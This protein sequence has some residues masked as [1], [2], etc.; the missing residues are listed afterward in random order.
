[1]KTLQ[2]VLDEHP[3]IEVAKKLGLQEPV[4][5][6][7]NW[8]CPI[9]DDQNP[10]LSISSEKNLWYCHTC[11]IGGNIY[12]LIMKVSDC[13]FSNALKFLGEEPLY[14]Q[15]K[16]KYTRDNY[17]ESHGLSEE[18]CKKFGFQKSF[19]QSK[20]GK[21]ESIVFPNLKGEHHRVFKGKNKFLTVGE[22]TLWKSDEATKQII[23]AEGESKA[24]LISQETGLVAWASTGGKGTFKKAWISEFDDVEEI[25]VV[26]DNDYPKDA[27]D[28]RLQDKVLRFLPSEKV[29][30][31]NFSYDYKDITDWFVEGKHTG[32]EFKELLKDAQNLASNYSEGDMYAPRNNWEEMTLEELTPLLDKTIKKDHAAKTITFLAMLL[33]YTEDSQLNVIFS[34]DSSSGKSYVSLELGK[35]FPKEDIISLGGASPTS[36]IHGNGNYDKEKKATIVDLERKI[37]IFK[38]MQI[39]ALLEKLRS[40]LSHDEKET[41]Y[42]VTDRNKRGQNRAKKI[43]IKGFPSV[44]F[45]SAKYKIDEQELTRSIVLSPEYS[46]EKIE[47]SIT[48]LSQKLRDPAA[49]SDNL[50]HDPKRNDLMKR[51]QDIRHAHINNVKI[52]NIE[53]LEQEFMQ[54]TKYLPPRAM[55]DYMKVASLVKALALLNLWNRKRDGK[56]ILASDSDID[57]A[58]V[59]WDKI[60]ISQELG[61]SPAL[62]DF[63]T[64]I[65]WEA[66]EQ[67]TI[68]LSKKD[69]QAK[70]VQLRKKQIPD[71]KLRQEILEMLLN[72]G[73]ISEERDESDKRNILYSAVFKPSPETVHTP[74]SQHNLGSE[75]KIAEEKNGRI[76]SEGVVYTRDQNS[77][78][79][80]TREPL[81]SELNASKMPESF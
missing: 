78:E 41:I 25:V 71:W 13:N 75:T 21:M 10:S 73:V 49:F 17:L 7:S 3:I 76:Y 68:V 4:N 59:L 54:R 53:K 44:I 8:L 51:I 14:E 30:V 80:Q 70:H 19:Y 61:L 62:F 35:L 9:H 29:K 27:K 67:G 39:Y 43:I 65:I 40:I 26:N 24:A 45:A 38:D 34:G 22:V 72:A 5:G 69:I 16:E 66:S 2:Q 23:L 48:L 11:G 63:Y 15:K 42:M 12:G 50:V 81:I 36:F 47:N 57:S 1:M 46:R 58:Y 79:V 6:H 52:P 64:N 56:D 33:A 77:L 18:T 37:I 60:R 55:R 74:S 32:E 31:L 28:S 20:Y